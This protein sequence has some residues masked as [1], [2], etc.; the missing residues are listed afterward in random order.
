MKYFKT[1][2]LILLLLT[3]QSSFSS[4]SMVLPPDSIINYPCSGNTF[5]TLNSWGEIQEWQLNNGAVSGGQIILNNPSSWSLSYC[6]NSI[7]Q[8]F[9]SGIVGGITYY[10]SPS[11]S[12]INNP[13]M[14]YSN[15]AGYKQFQYYMSGYSL[16]YYNGSNLSYLFNANFQVADISVDTLGRAWVVI[17]DFSNNA[18]LK[19]V[20]TSGTILST[21]TYSNAISLTNA[22]GMFSLN[23]TIYVGFGNNNPV[24][25][26]KIVPVIINGTS[27]H[28]GNPISFPETQFPYFLDMASCQGGRNQ[29]VTGYNS[30]SRPKLKIFPNPTTDIININYDNITSIDLFNSIGDKLATFSPDTKTINFHNFNLGIYTLKIIV[31]NKAFYEKIVLT[32]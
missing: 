18:F 19:V 27:F 12:V 32:K 30:Q 20:D 15:S 26:A 13:S 10:N 2:I 16:Y 8:T 11:W 31:D 6:G 21:Y 4:N 29:I 7:D 24:F 23:D 17:E 25:P 22:Y 5:W 3:S 1:K 28:F 14:G 9:F